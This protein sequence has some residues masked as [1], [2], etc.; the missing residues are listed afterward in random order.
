MPHS[1][2]GRLQHRF[3][4]DCRLRRGAD[5]RRVYAEGVRVGD[6]RLL[7][8]GVRNHLDVTRMGLSVSRRH[9]SAVVRNRRKRCLR[10]AFRLVRQELPVGLDLV[11]IPRQGVAGTVADYRAALPKLARRLQTKLERRSGDPPRD[12]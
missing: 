1:G 11:L 5:F 7:M 6:H 3:P 10:E 9:G 2:D 8:V 4:A 12:S